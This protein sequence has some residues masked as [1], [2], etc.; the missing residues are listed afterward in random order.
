MGIIQMKSLN[1][2]KSTKRVIPTIELI[3]NRPLSAPNVDRIFTFQL[4]ASK[5]ARGELQM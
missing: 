1:R 5:T 2:R 4:N 3:Q